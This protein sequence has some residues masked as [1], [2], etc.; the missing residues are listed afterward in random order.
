MAVQREVAESLI[1]RFERQ[2][3]LQGGLEGIC[4]LLLE[5]DRFQVVLLR[6]HCLHRLAARFDSL[7]A[8]APEQESA[9][10]EAFLAAVAPKV[11]M[12]RLAHL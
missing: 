10:F 1:T 6:D 7:V 12:P 5:A 8:D 3:Q 9:V 2:P 4:R 11:R